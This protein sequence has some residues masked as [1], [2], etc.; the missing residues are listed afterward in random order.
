MILLASF[1]QTFVIS[2]L[3]VLLMAVLFGAVYFLKTLKQMK[4]AQIER[5]DIEMRIKEGQK[6]LFLNGLIG[7][8]KAIHQESVEILVMS[9]TLLEVRK[10]SINEILN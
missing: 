1:G 5:N 3:A 2:M 6:V 8:V 7:E 10:E 4:I 9:Q